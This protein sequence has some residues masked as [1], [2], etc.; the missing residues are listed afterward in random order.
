MF[1]NLPTAWRHAVKNKTS[2]VLNVTGL[3]LGIAT[4]LVIAIWA[5]R[6]LSYDNFHPNVD[7]K[8]R[9]W[10]TFTSEAE[11]F[12]QAP[13]GVALGAHLPR[14]VPDIKT[15]CRIFNT[16]FKV[17]QGSETNFENNV[18]FADSTFF[19][20]FGFQII[21]GP[22]E[23]LLR[24]PQHVIITREMAVKYFG[25]V[26]DALNAALY[27]DDEAATVVAIAENTPPDS[28]IQF[29]IIV[30]YK[31]LH[32]YALREFNEDIDN[33]WLGGWP[34]TYVE[35]ADPAKRD[36]VERKVNEVVEAH[37]KQAWADNKMSYTYFLQPVRDIHLHSDLRYDAA[38]NGSM[39]TVRIFIAVAAL[40]L[41]L[42]CFN[43]INLT[44]A[45]S[46][47]RAKE[48]S[49]RKVSGARHVQL[50]QQ[51]FLET[52]LVTLLAVVVGVALAQLALPAFST[53]M[54][55]PYTFPADIKHLSL[56]AV[57]T[58]GITILSGIY[59]AVVL[60]SFRPVVALR[61]RFLGGQRGQ[62][63]RKAL[64]IV[65]FSIS[66][67]LLICILT[68]NRQMQFIGEK[69]LGYD[70]TGVITVDFNGDQTV[71]QNYDVI[72]NT[73]LAAPYVE[74]T[75]LHGGNVVG[76]LGNG[77]I[78]TEDAEGKEVVT[79]IYRLSV[80]PDYFE[81]YKM[82]FLAGRGF[83]RANSDSSK[84]V[85]VNEAAV[86]NLGWKSNEDA[87]GKPFGNGE[88]A[89]YVIGVVR[90][91]H[92]EN[93][94]STVQPLM[95]RYANDGGSLSMR[96]Q[97]NHIAD[98]IQLLSET[99]SRIVPGVPLQY[100]FVSDELRQ[101]YHRERKLEAI[102][103]AAAALSFFIACLGLFGL[104]TF[105]IRQRIQE[106]SIRKVLG[107]SVAGIVVLLTRDFSRLVLVSAMLA[108]PAGYFLMNGWLE[109]F[110]YRTSIG[111]NIFAIAMFVPLMIAILTV[112]AQ[113]IKAAFINAAK[114]LRSE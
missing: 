89:R 68:V 9:I 77:W 38:N 93:L 87:L 91:F 59:P 27:L 72:R 52:F 102:F 31:A 79:S 88:Q 66:T 81:T 47:K 60:A 111:W 21:A 41:L 114:T 35:L 108:C 43:Y 34:N 14:H 29:D 80:D 3:A 105:M 70:E 94:H 90:D 112:S 98:A 32:A 62:V 78:A 49:L 26:S 25:S 33:T 55:Q 45:T 64:V 39:V 96:V 56:L 50:M 16:G 4:C 6:E 67:V 54:E 8:F 2:V 23:Q 61:G 10:N 65:Q 95:I 103:Y 19:T 28:H 104:S 83:S 92:F 58:I 11:T 86:K 13:S 63:F 75:S 82:E 97:T 53:W 71:I 113:A 44:T 42:A 73:L 1:L 18:I 37:S 20:F 106:I 17:R 15:A 69:P 51:F 85:V 5:E 7:A 48:V 30:P 57:L 84:A 107:A 110:S 36:E 109:T 40:V 99:W 12:S 46:A 76:G 22:K 74:E 100:S 101:Q 24:D